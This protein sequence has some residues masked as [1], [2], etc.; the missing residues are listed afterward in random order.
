MEYLI[1]IKRRPDNRE[2]RKE[3]KSMIKSVL[4]IFANQKVIR[5]KSMT[6]HANVCIERNLFRAIQSLENL[7]AIC[8]NAN[9]F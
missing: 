9:C 3:K 1:G 2:I 4:V 8:F 6:L 5:Y 7:V